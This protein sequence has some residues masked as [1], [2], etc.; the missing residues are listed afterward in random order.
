LGLE[1]EGTLCIRKPVVL[2]VVSKPRH[3]AWGSLKHS[4][5]RN[6]EERPRVT[7]NPRN[8]CFAHSPLDLPQDLCTAPC[9]D[10]ICSHLCFLDGAGF[11]NDYEEGADL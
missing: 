2:N 11:R 7:L 8:V 1:V 5:G 10:S 6:I 3:K 9:L 4:P